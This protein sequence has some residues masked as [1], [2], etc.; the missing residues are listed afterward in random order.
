[1]RSNSFRPAGRARARRHSLWATT[2]TVGLVAASVLAATGSGASAAGRH[3]LVM[4]NRASTAGSSGATKPTVV[5]VHGAW[6]DS[7]SWDGVVARLQADGYPVDVFP[8]P[9]QSLKDDSLALRD[10][11]AVIPGDV[12]LVGHS[13]GGAVVTDAATGNANVKALV[14]I[15]A[16]APSEGSAVGSYVGPDSAVSDPSV[17]VAVGAT[18]QLYVKQSV[19]PGAFANDIPPVEA[20]VLAATQRPIAVGALGEASTTPAW[21]TIPSWYEVGTIDKVIPP[22]T[23]LA[24]AKT[25]GAHI[26]R[27]RTSHLPMVSQPGTVTRTIETAARAT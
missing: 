26:I 13:Y 9:L 27:A 21:L 2:A 15:D 23:Q 10:Y 6:A 16:F 20:R 7:G 1:M 22:A 8:T 25:A 11:L 18:G 5:L 14:Y 24:M 12:V 17:F 19:F 3:A 4:T